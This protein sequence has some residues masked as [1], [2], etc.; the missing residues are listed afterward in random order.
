MLWWHTAQLIC[1][2]WYTKLQP[3]GSRMPHAF[4]Q[5]GGVP[6]PAG[7]N[8]SIPRSFR[9]LYLRV[10]KP[11]RTSSWATND[12]LLLSWV[13]FETLLVSAV[14][15]CG[16]GG[17]TLVSSVL[18]TRGRS[19]QEIATPLQTQLSFLLLI[20]AFPPRSSRSRLEQ[21]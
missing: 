5:D 9:L 7:G 1:P 8:C 14:N 11:P 20:P 3:R 6:R 15:A 17:P 4:S 2:S 12:S 16:L 21:N 10:R 13:H 18:R 19:R